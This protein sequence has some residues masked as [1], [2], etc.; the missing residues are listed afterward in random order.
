M[1]KDSD[2][3]VAKSDHPEQ[4]ILAGQVGTV[5]CCFT[6]PNEAYEVEFLGEDGKPVAQLTLLPDELEAYKF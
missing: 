1:F 5:V 3:V 2:V 4:K 6:A